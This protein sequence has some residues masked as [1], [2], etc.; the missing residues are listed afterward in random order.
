[1]KWYKIDKK[2]KPKCKKAYKLLEGSPEDRAILKELQKSDPDY[3]P[4]DD[5]T[6]KL[7]EFCTP[8]Y[9]YVGIRTPT[10]VDYHCG[11]GTG[12]S[13]FGQP[14]GIKTIK[15]WRNPEIENTGDHEGWPAMWRAV[16]YCGARSSCGNSHQKQINDQLTTGLYKNIKGEWHL[17]IEL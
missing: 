3:I 15:D 10:P 6:I 8:Y 11:W 2:N 7:L 13:A 1:M 9:E 14:F 12:F 4:I 16:E 5:K 17:K